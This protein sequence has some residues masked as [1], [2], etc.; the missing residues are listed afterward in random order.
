MDTTPPSS[1]LPLAIASL[2]LLAWTPIAAKSEEPNQAAEAAR[3][4]L[5]ILLGGKK[6]KKTPSN[7]AVP[8][9]QGEQVTLDEAQQQDREKG[10]IGGAAIG[11]AAGAIVHEDDRAKGA[12]VGG[13]AGAIV[14]AVVGNE[15]ANK[16][17]A[18]AARYDEI[19]QAIAAAQQKIQILQSDTARI[20]R[21]IMLRETQVKS[22]AA[23]TSAN[24]AAIAANK[25]TLADVEADLKA[26][27]SASQNAMVAIKVLEDEIKS[28]ESQAK[29]DAELATRK[30]Q[31]EAKRQELLVVLQKI[32]DA[33]SVLMA[34]RGSLGGPARS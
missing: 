11:A 15:M 9:P 10:M 12:V 16:R 6:K 22:A 21:R 30:S 4:A 8:Q 31:L 7:A 28:V 18:Y 19:D 3:G 24:Q 29:A 23:Q 13:A 34:Q 14:G 27:D 25:Q 1:R 26:N 32:N 33:D 17:G 2:L 5:D 20:E